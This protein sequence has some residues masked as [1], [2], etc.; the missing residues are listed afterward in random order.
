MCPVLHSWYLVNNKTVN[1]KNDITINLNKHY[2]H[3]FI[4]TN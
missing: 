1:S 3:K 4:Q 2:L